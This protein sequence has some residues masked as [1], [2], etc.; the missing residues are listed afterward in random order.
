MKTI[1][2]DVAVIGVGLGGFAA[3]R[4]LLERGLTVAAI[5][6]YPWIGGQVTSQ[7][8]CVLDE[9]HDPVGEGIGYSRR[10][11]EFR[12]GLRKHY[13]TNY[14]LSALGAGQLY[15]NSGNSMNSHMVAEPHVAQEVLLETL[16]PYIESGQLVIMTGWV[17]ESARCRSYKL[18][19]VQC[20]S[21][22]DP[23]DCFEVLASFFLDGTEAGDLYPIIPV[24][25][26]LGADGPVF[27]ER[28][29]DSDADVAAIQSSTVCFAVEYVPGG[30]FTIPRPADYEYWKESH[31]PFFLDT[32]GASAAEPAQM[33]VRKERSDGRLLPPAFYY[34][35]VIDHRNFDDPRRA[36]SRTIINTS[37]N[38]YRSEPMVGPGV[39][40]RDVYEKACALSRAYLY[41]LQAEAPR[42]EGGFGYPELRPCPEITGTP[43][44]FAMAPYIR[45]GRRL[46][47]HRTIVEEDIA[48]HSRPGARA[49]FFEDSVGLGGFVID[50]HRR[51][52]NA[53]RFHGGVHSRPYQIPLSA[54]V[55]PELENFACA[56]KCIG[57][58]QITNGAYRLHNIEWA[59]GE[60]AGELAAYCLENRIAQPCLT[61]KSLFSFQQRLI[62]AG[63]PLFWYED[64]GFDHP[65]FEAVQTLSITGLWPVSSQHLRFDA[66]HSVARSVPTIKGVFENL[67]RLGVDATRLREVVLISHGTRKADAAHRI[68]RFLEDHGW[69]EELWESGRQKGNALSSIEEEIPQPLA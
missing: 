63:V 6:E 69:P 18:E 9:Y 5:E 8:L 26:R 30:D 4:A 57:T 14:Q 25:Y 36:C 47:A 53:P 2:T 38:D 59:I 54:M 44:G 68:L 24:S 52:G 27:G 16:R 61:G 46:S 21:V 45:E 33:F 60:A 62:R 56:G 66:H 51:T 12:E 17:A 22:H 29:S 43:D 55:T 15:L 40:T 34:R 3:V 42:D 13:T 35:S 23:A 1:Q 67:S 49:A 32:P 28:H 11:A 65:A 37:C 50:I 64:I 7:A 39:D 48:I 41:W 31:G 19:A 10:Y 58:T 20:R